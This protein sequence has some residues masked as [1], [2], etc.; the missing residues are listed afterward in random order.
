VWGGVDW[1][2]CVPPTVERSTPLGV[3]TAKSNE[4]SLDLVSVW[5]IWIVQSFLSLCRIHA[6]TFHKQ[7]FAE[8]KPGLLAEDMLKFNNYATSRALCRSGF[9]VV[10]L[11]KKV[12]LG[13]IIV[14]SKA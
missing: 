2:L 3:I 5:V 12:K 9:E 6:A 13:Y 8:H 14:R 7:R 10:N 1:P 4:T 11:A